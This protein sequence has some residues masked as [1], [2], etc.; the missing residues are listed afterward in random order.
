MLVREARIIPS[1]KRD[2]N[3]CMTINPAPEEYGSQRSRKP[4]IGS[5]SGTPRAIRFIGGGVVPLRHV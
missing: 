2:R 4:S 5:R 1:A 3:G